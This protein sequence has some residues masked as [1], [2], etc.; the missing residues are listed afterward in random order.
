MGYSLI[1]T[2]G[3][4]NSSTK[5]PRVEVKFVG[6]CTAQLDTRTVYLRQRHGG[7]E[8][9]LLYSLLEICSADSSSV[10]A[11]YAQQVCERRVTV[12]I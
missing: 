7:L 1:A 10:S 9:L 5:S 4:N 12:L 8:H 2:E 11:M 6:F 3:Y